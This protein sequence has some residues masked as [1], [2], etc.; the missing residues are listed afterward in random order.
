MLLVF[1]VPFKSFIATISPAEGDAGS[2]TVTA[3][4]DRDWETPQK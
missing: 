1:A 4:P 3:P 2:V